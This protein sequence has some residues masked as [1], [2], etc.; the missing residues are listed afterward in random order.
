MRF[1]ALGL[2]FGKVFGL[3]SGGSLCQSNMEAK[4]D[5]FQQDSG[6]CLY[7]PFCSC[8]LVCESIVV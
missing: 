8:M 1:R 5:P 7:G 4:M 6:L 3:V 2:G